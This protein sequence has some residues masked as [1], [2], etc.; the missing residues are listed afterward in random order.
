MQRPSAGTLVEPG[1]E[2][3]RRTRNAGNQTEIRHL[4]QNG[5]RGESRPFTPPSSSNSR[6]PNIGSDELGSANAG[7]SA[8]A[9]ELA[10]RRWIAGQAPAEQPAADSGRSRRHRSSEV[11]AAANRARLRH[12][13]AAAAT[14]IGRRR[15]RHRWM[16]GATVRTRRAA[17]GADRRHRPVRSWICGSRSCGRPRA[18]TAD[19]R[20]G[21]A[22]LRWRRYRAP[23]LRVELR[24]TADREE[25]PARRRIAV[26]AAMAR[27]VAAAAAV[28]DTPAAAVVVAH[29]GGGGHRRRSSLKAWRR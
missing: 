7:S 6:P 16:R 8:W 27:R 20:A 3:L 17:T 21:V 2:Q 14:G 28:A 1:D 22:Q 12:A 13:A 15:V 24:A 11:V 29:S 18:A 9:R 25:H 23:A 19:I 10:A 26:A 4:G 5:N